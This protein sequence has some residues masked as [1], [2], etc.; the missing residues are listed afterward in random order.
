M[1]YRIGL[2]ERKDDGFSARPVR[3]TPPASSRFV[4]IARV[5]PVFAAFASL[6]LAQEFRSGPQ[7]GTPEKPV[8]VPHSFEA[9]TFNGKHADRFRSLVCEND[10]YPTVLI[11]AKD[12]ETLKDPAPLKGL[13]AKLEETI[14][15][16]ETMDAYPEVTGFSAYIVFLSDAAQTS[17]VAKEDDPAKLVKEATDRRALYARV[18]PWGDEL[19]K[20]TVGCAVPDAVKGYAVN[21]AADLTILYYDA[22]VVQDNFAYAAGFGEADAGK[23]AARVEQRL[24]AK[25]AALKAKRK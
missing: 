11:L 9:H 10:F 23:V 6:A 19:K 3:Q 13:L 2:P 18:R 20:V 16:Y 22:F 12:P 25:I 24:D 21:A 15:K 14:G 4:M 1:L 5:L 8:R 17:L 7:P